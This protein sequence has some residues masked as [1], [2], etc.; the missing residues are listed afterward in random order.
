M[1]RY[2]SLNELRDYLGFS[3]TLGQGQDALMQFA[4]DDAESAI[5]DHT[6]RSFVGTAGTAYYNRFWQDKV[7]GQQLFLDQDLH[8]LTG[9]LN[10]DSTTIPL[11]SVWTEPRNQ[12]PPYRILRLKSSYAWVWNTDSDVVV[13]GTFGYGTVAPDAIRRATIRLAAYY[14]RLKDVGPGDVSGFPEGGE[15]TYPKGIPD[16]VKLILEKY[17]SRS[18]GAV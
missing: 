6:R 2:A 12:G 7:V 16:D 10:G 15:V 14:Y 4:L 9:L 8:T 18:G 1:S 13:S 17:R 11:G 3:G 5:D